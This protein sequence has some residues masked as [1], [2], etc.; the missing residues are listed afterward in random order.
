MAFITFSHFRLCVCVWEGGKGGGGHLSFP[1]IFTLA[2]FL[3]SAEIILPADK[4]RVLWEDDFI[5]RKLAF[6]VNISIYT[7]K[8]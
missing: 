5:Q 7:S 3:T 4:E 2:S 8:S 1:H 6:C